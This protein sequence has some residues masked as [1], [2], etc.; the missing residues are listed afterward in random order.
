MDDAVYVNVE[1]CSFIDMNFCF[2][3]DCCYE[4]VPNW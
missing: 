1:M 2:I 3:C 4:L